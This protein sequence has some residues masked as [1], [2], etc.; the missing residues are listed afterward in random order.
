MGD[1]LMTIGQMAEASGLGVKALREYDRLGILKPDRKRTG[2]RYRLYAKE[3]LTVARKIAWYRQLGLPLRQILRLLESGNPD[4]ERRILATV[5]GRTEARL[6]GGQTALH[7]LD[8]ALAG[9]KEGVMTTEKPVVLDREAERRL[10]AELFNQTWR[11]LEMET[12][13]QEQ[14]DEMMHCAHASRYHWGRVGQP[15]HLAR[16]EWQISRVYAVL[17]RGE[18]AAFHA[19]RCLAIV[20]RHQLSAFDLAEAYEALARAALVRGDRTE[21]KRFADVARSAG[22][23]IS[24]A[25]DSRIFSGDLA[26]L[27]V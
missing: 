2:S 19:S 16:G 15:V 23:T 3:Q 21:A 18:P 22:A 25:E 14:D 20:Q 17:G 24:D 10:A 7:R 6:W 27:A 5:R 26:T 12:R 8:R 4:V 11:L 1:A 9:D 13:T